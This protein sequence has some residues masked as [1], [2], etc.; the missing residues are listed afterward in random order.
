MQPPGDRPAAQL[1]RRALALAL[2]L[3]SAAA[4]HVTGPRSIKTGR[5]HYNVAIQQTNN[6][7]LLLN[8]VRLRYRDT[9]LFLEIASVT[10][11]F[12][13]DVGGGATGTVNP[14]NA[15]APGSVGLQGS[16]G[17]TEKPTVAYVPL[18]GQ[19][20]VTQLLSPMDPRVIL[21]MYHSGWAIDRIFKICVQRLGPLQN[22]TRAS[23]P[24]PSTPPRFDEFFQA[25]AALRDLWAA[26]A[27][28]MGYLSDEHG[29]SLVLRIDE[30]AADTA[31]TRRIHEL[32]H[33]EDRPL[34]LVL[35]D[36]EPGGIA[37]VPRSVIAAMFYLSH[38]VEVPE[39]DRRAGKV[40]ITRDPQGG[41]FSWSALT[42]G[43]MRIKSRR[44]PPPQAYV[45]VPYRDRWFYIDDSDL[46]SKSTFALLTQ[47]LELQS[48]EIKATGP[49]LTLPVGT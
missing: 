29:G 8:L 27:L 32:L 18:Q 35:S 47:L 5:D 39:G 23:G 30:S 22:A 40:T 11:N 10:T 41:E 45:A 20:F 24:T 16:I 36:T 2:A 26:G 7:Q 37:V 3:T 34:T 6:E 28:D 42:G 21:L 15:A 9:P 1:R 12:T 33:L 48:G 43:L 38:G 25:T 4:C 17:Y 46:D 13:F 14:G 31:A 19:R 44:G 49:V